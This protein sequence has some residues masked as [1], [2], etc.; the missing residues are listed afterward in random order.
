MRLLHLSSAVVYGG[1]EEH[2]RALMTALRK[3]EPSWSVGLAAPAG[4]PLAARLKDSGITLH[5]LE[6][7]GKR[8]PLAPL[9][10]R[11]LVREHRY[12][13][14]HSHGRREDLALVTGCAGLPGV[15][16]VTTLHDRV[17]MLPSGA[18]SATVFDRVY[19]RLL[20]RFN[21][22]MAVSRATLA[23][24][25]ELTGDRRKGHVAV[26]N[27]SDLSRLTGLRASPDFRLRHGIDASAL[28]LVLVARVRN[29]D[30]GK[31]GH[32]RLLEAMAA[33]RAGVHLVTIGE[34]EESA[35]ILRAHALKL[36]V[37]LT[38][39]GVLPEP[40][41]QVV[42]ADVAVLPSLY[43]GLPR[44][45]MEAMAVGLPVIASDVDG[46]R[47]LVTKDC[48]MLV[49]VHDQAAW[50]QAMENMASNPAR[51]RSMGEQGLQRIR[52][53]YSSDKMAMD[54][55]EAYRALVDA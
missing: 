7:G 2:V 32:L 33:S 49:P 25:V 21:R 44:S 43:E 18:R 1:A 20:P 24:Y 9:R 6:F 54:H 47:E 22:I 42:N 27:G 5:T 10:L 14:V 38:S 31:K 39:L 36:N 35:A 15:D 12:R 51:R 3:L 48:G 52:E 23:D 37:G 53:H 4:S 50:A 29:G 46:I 40:L 26:T 17:N 41:Q 13:I 30:F 16:L 11:R 19:L 34:D 28:L 8:D 45:L 55:I